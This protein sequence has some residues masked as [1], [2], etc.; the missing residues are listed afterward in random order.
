LAIEAT[1]A[2]EE[3]H[4]IQNALKRLDFFLETSLYEAHTRSISNA[5]RTADL[6]IGGSLDLLTTFRFVYPPAAKIT[7]LIETIVTHSS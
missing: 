2:I 4:K 1:I 7:H 6:L 5:T 3:I